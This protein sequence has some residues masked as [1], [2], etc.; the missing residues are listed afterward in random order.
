VSVARGLEGGVSSFC[1]SSEEMCCP[2]WMS[3]SGTL[4]ASRVCETVVMWARKGRM[5]VCGSVEGA[6][7]SERRAVR[8]RKAMVDGAMR[9]FLLVDDSA[10][11]AM[12]FGRC[13]GVSAQ[14]R[15]CEI[16]KSW[17]GRISISP[18]TSPHLSEQPSTHQ[19]GKPPTCLKMSTW[20]ASVSSMASGMSLF[21]CIRIPPPNTLAVSI[22][23]S[24]S[25][26]AQPVRAML[27]PTRRRT[28]AASAQSCTPRSAGKKRSR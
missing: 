5:N 2:D 8:A 3:G 23:T 24:A 10:G 27:P 22:T 6:S 14:A 28:S 15:T 26:S 25:A 1:L 21:S 9:G 20:N 19:R 16:A 18:P 4:P 17:R 13:N 11:D 12:K 7:R